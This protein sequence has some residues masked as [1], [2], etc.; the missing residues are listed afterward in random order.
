MIERA[1]L[2]AILVACFSSLTAQAPLEC[3]PDRGTPGTFVY[4]FAD[5]LSTAEEAEFNQSI[6]S[7]NDTTPNSIVVVTHP[8]FVEKNRLSLPQASG[9]SGGWEMPSLTTVWLLHFRPKQRNAEA[10]CSLL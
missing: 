4:D 10:R 2:T 5:V 3:L 1:M 6:R 7:L 8:D 9:R